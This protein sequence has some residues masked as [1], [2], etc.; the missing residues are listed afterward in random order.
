MC[1]LF[2]KAREQAKES[3][4]LAALQKRRVRRE[5]ILQQRQQ[6][7]NDLRAQRQVC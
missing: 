7:L 4:R 5:E 1:I 2:Y 3:E 6:E